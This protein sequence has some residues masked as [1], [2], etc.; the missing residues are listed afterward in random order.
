M[1]VENFAIFDMVYD[2]NDIY[3]ILAKSSPVIESNLSQL[4]AVGA[5]CNS[6]TFSE[7][8]AMKSAIHEKGSDT[9]GV[10]GNATGMIILVV[11]TKVAYTG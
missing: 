1:H 4:A 10:A 3:N 7:N 11:F 8:D 6:A 5:I 9:K 2:S